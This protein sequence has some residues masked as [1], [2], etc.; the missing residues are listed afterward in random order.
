[1]LSASHHLCAI[2]RGNN[3]IGIVKRWRIDEG[4]EGGSGKVLIARGASHQ[5]RRLMVKSKE[6]W[7]FQQCEKSLIG[8]GTGDDEK[9][10]RA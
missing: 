6:R 3:I 1:M 4:N 7:H 5:R 2:W 8:G 10:H 9:Y